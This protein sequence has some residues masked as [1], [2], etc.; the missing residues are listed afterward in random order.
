MVVEADLEAPV[1]QEAPDQVD[2]DLDLEDPAQNPR[3]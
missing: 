3:L 2:R 1:A